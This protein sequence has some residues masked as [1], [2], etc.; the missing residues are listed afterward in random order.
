MLKSKDNSSGKD[1]YVLSPGDFYADECDCILAT[2]TGSCV[3]V[4]L[5]EW[6]RNIGAMGHFILPGS[7][8][9]REIYKDEI[10]AHGINSMEH[11]VAMIV[12]LGG[13]RKNLRAK[14][15][16]AAYLSGNDGLDNVIKGNITFLHDYFAMEHI[17]IEKEDLGG[18]RRRKLFFYPT[19][20]KVYRRL[21]A[22]NEDT[23][24]FV[25]M[26]KEYID[27]TIREKG[28]FG[29]IVMFQ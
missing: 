25:I 9:T 1:M 26:E 14:L 11:L 22:K 24:E 3:V 10:A 2:V 4:C 15:F 21:L 29:K 18:E 5:H 8:G 6:K 16:G 12:K 23:S 7:P 28:S 19:T 13:D 20:G 17:S 27:R